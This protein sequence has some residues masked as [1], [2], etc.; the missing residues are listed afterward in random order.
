MPVLG[1]NENGFGRSC[2]CSPV[3]KATLY[4]RRHDITIQTHAVS[5]ALP[6]IVTDDD[7]PVLDLKARPRSHPLR[8]CFF[9]FSIRCQYLS[10]MAKLRS[11]SLLNF[12]SQLVLLA[13]D[14]L[15]RGVLEEHLLPFLIVVD[16]TC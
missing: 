3:A 6:R 9:R 4:L 7:A 1:G 5:G 10:I 12:R 8:S 16:G 2:C 14:L 11:T 15:I 13:Y